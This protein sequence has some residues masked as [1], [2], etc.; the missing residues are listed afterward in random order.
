MGNVTTHY[1]AMSYVM[2]S[3]YKFHK[4]KTEVSYNYGIKY[5]FQKLI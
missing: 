5:K 2:V 3:S 4:K 1:N